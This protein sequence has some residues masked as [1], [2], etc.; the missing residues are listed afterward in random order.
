MDT[1][2]RRHFLFVAATASGGLLLGCRL[3]ERRGDKAAAAGLYA[4]ALVGFQMTGASTSVKMFY[5]PL[6]KAGA[7]ARTMLVAAAAA[8]WGVDPSTCRAQRGVV[9]HG[10]SGRSLSYGALANKAAGQ[11][12]PA[13]IA[14][15]DPKDFT[16]IGTRAKRLDTPSKVNGTAQF[17]IDVRVPGMKIATLAISPVIGGTV[18]SLDEA[19]ALSVKGVHQVV[20]F[21]DVVAVVAD[22]MWA[23]KQ[24]LAA[25][26]LTWDDGSNGRI[27]TGDVL[28][29]L[30]A[31][32]EAGGRIARKDG[33]GAAALARAA[34]R[35][36]AVYHVPFLAHAAM[37][38]LCVTVHVRPD[39][40]EVWTG[41]QVLTRAQATAAQVTGLPLEKVIVHNQLIGGAF[42]RRLEHEQGA[43]APVARSAS[44][45]TRYIHSRLVARRT[46]AIAG[47]RATSAPMPRR[48]RP[49]S[50]VLCSRTRRRHTGVAA[51]WR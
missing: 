4:N 6:R 27:R 31:A 17:G 9:T 37:E 29:R 45:M 44:I 19:K 25:L 12:V 14:L 15:K 46:R 35:I 50:L 21:D 42:G 48:G 16:L 41:S 32:S 39:A 26:G 30:A 51:T 10:P 13:Q 38:P 24:G 49:F 36:D 23:A 1:L 3:D 5:E 43:A 33:D 8:T 20:R 18:A 22:H 47:A 40:C 2:S 11:P 34:K 7:A 28:H